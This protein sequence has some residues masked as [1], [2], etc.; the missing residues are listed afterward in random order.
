[1]TLG[2]TIQEQRTKQNMSQ[3]DLAN[4]LE[5]SRQSVSK[6]ETDA[7]VPELSKLVKMCEVFHISLDELVRKTKPEEAKSEQQNTHSPV[8][9]ILF[10]AQNPARKIIAIVFLSVAAGLFLLFCILTGPISA[11]IFSS[12]FLLLGTIYLLI[13][14]HTAFWCFLSIY[15]LLYAYLRYATGIRFWWVFNGWLYREGL[16]IHA[17]IAWGMTLGLVFLLFSAA[18]IILRKRKKRV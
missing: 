13:K 7:S 11:L 3:G 5:V 9:E 8:Q 14:R 17:L 2:E 10:P 12:P 4:E 6:W 15:V 16:E 1:M 18:C